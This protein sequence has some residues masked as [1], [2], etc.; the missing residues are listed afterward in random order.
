MK[1]MKRNT[2]KWIAVF[3]ALMLTAGGAASGAGAE[4]T[5]PVYSA[6]DL[7]TSRDLK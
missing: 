2:G 4:G 6:S 5:D 1:N 3:A 7:F